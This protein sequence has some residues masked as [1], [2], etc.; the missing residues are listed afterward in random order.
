MQLFHRKLSQWIH[1]LNVI[2]FISKQILNWGCGKYKLN[3]LRNWPCD[4]MSQHV[5]GHHNYQGLSDF[6][7]PANRSALMIQ[8]ALTL[9]LQISFW[10]FYQPLRFFNSKKHQWQ[11]EKVII[12]ASVYGTFRS[13]KYCA[14]IESCWYFITKIN[15]VCTSNTSI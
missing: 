15:K 6:K 11:H 4:T 7:F 10:L 14:G 1:S 12:L 8:L 3:V 9:D 2:K 13:Y 5:I